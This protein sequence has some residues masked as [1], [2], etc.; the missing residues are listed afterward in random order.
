LGDALEVR[1]S[2]REEMKIYIKEEHY[3]EAIALFRA[4]Q[5]FLKHAEKDPDGEIDDLRARDLAFKIL[6]AG[7]NFVLLEQRLT[8]ALSIFLHW[9]GAAEPKMLKKP[10]NPAEDKYLTEFQKLRENI[11]DLYGAEAFTIMH[12]LLQTHY[13]R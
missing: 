11:Q 5:N 12:T 4:R 3:K 13:H 10:T 7:K 2:L 1:L 9:F 6:F 8:P